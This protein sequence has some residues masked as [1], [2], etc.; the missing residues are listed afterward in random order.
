MVFKTASDFLGAVVGGSEA[1][2][3]RILQE[4]A[5]CV[6]V[7]DE[8]YALNPKLGGGKSAAAGNDPFREA[9]INTLV[10]VIQGV[11]GENRAVLLLG[12]KNEMTDF[13]TNANPGLARRFA[14]SQAL[15]FDDYTA[16]ELQKILRARLAKTQIRC[17][18]AAE[19]TAL[20][21]LEREKKLPNFGNGGAVNNL[22]SEAMKRLEERLKSMP[23]KERADAPLEPADFDPDSA[24]DGSLDEIFSGLLGCGGVIREL[25]ALHGTIEHEMKRQTAD[26]FRNVPFTFIFSGPPGVGTP[27]PACR[28][29]LLSRS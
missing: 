10:E 22:V 14:L 4:S 12:Y 23:A 20:A 16:D 17:T 29:A 8:A 27:P 24:R 26:P 15:E 5:G 6:L 21:V 9:V 28:H 19:K 13:I 1:N 3:R 7:I 11:P 25:K 18:A 2:T